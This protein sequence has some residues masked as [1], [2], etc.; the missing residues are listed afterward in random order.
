MPQQQQQQQPQFIFIELPSFRIR[1]KN[2]NSVTLSHRQ[3]GHVL[4]RL[5]Q[6]NS[7]NSNHADLC[8]VSI[9]FSGG[10]TDLWTSSSS[11]SSSHN[12]LNLHA[13]EN[14][15]LS[16]FQSFDSPGAYPIVDAMLLAAK[17]CDDC[18]G[19]FSL[20]GKHLH[21]Q[22]GEDTTT[23]TSAASTFRFNFRAKFTPRSDKSYTPVFYLSSSSSSS[24]SLSAEYLSD[25][26]Y[27]LGQMSAGGLG[28]SSSSSSF[29]LTNPST[30]S[31]ASSSY[32]I[33]MAQGQGQGQ[34]YHLY[35]DDGSPSP[36]YALSGQETMTDAEIAE[37][38]TRA[39][40]NPFFW[41]GR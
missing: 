28:S 37:A 6:F 23:T 24:S 31:T 39:H 1:D 22:S 15:L 34:P 10:E 33:R 36:W 3:M 26:W 32:G 2:N 29:G 14:L 20:T 41:I 25:L 35:G 7:N 27:Q 19:Y 11:S 16:Y 17:P 4:S 30:T 8:V 18:M 5:Q 13:E 21:F 40:M 12:G 38:I 9:L